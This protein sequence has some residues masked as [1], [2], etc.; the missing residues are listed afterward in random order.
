MRTLG[1]V[2]VDLALA[3]RADLGG[4]SC[5]SFLRLLH[6]GGSLVDGLD[7]AEQNEG[8]QQ[9]VDDGIDE[10]AQSDV[11]IVDGHYE[12][13]EVKAADHADDG[14]DDI[15]YQGCHDGCESAADDDTD[16]H[17]HYVAA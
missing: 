12:G 11:G 2:L 6:D 7:D 1:S 4:G 9:E 5:G 16:C 15:L 3:V 8:D 17:V 10:L 13:A 14:S